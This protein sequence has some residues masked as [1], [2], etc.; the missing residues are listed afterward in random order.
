[1]Q[2]L[3]TQSHQHIVTSTQI[4]GN[5]NRS[6]NFDQNHGDIDKINIISNYNDTNT[7]NSIINFID[8]ISKIET[9]QKTINT[10]ISALDKIDTTLKNNNASIGVANLFLED[11]TTNIQALYEDMNDQEN[12][13][14][15]SY[16]YF[17][18]IKGSLPMNFENIKKTAKESQEYL[19]EINNSLQ[20]KHSDLVS[21]IRDMLNKQ[22][23]QLQTNI[24]FSEKTSVKDDLNNLYG[25][26]TQVQQSSINSKKLLY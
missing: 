17:D 5:F 1:M 16:S 3:P 14:P 22:K 7:T 25:D 21:S 26:F 12:Q 11:I 9:Y 20:N 24:V 4:L 2:I 18:G 6:N 10:Q 15:K 13:F 8:R 19:K 23:Q